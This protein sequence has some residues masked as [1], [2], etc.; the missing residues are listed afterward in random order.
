MNSLSRPTLHGRSLPGISSRELTTWNG[1]P[2]RA[3]YFIESRMPGGIKWE[4]AAMGPAVLFPGSWDPWNGEY[5][6]SLIQRLLVDC[7]APAVLEGHYRWEGQDGY[8]DPAGVLVD[9]TEV[10]LNSPR[11]PTVVGL[12][13]AAPILLEALLASC[14]RAGRPPVAGVLVVGAG[15]PGFLNRLGRFTL[16]NYTSKTLKSI[17]SR[18]TYSGHT[19][20]SDNIIRAVDCFRGS[21]LAS[22]LAADIDGD[23]ESSFPVPVET[24][25]FRVDIATME[26]RMRIR[27]LF[28][29]T[30]ESECIP[31]YHTHLRDPSLADDRIV[32]FYKITQ[33]RATQ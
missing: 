28:G 33:A 32:E 9:L 20:T 14:E 26:S 10:L 4:E 30:H 24:L 7:G 3:M 15:V 23:F 8:F 25:Y 6:E 31:G 29:I 22:A 11:P 13:I 1:V 16:R 21:R 27:K 18:L 12:C 17:V 5:S 19:F 2:L